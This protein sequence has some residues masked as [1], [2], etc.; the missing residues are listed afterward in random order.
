MNYGDNMLHRKV[1]EKNTIWNRFIQEVTNRNFETLSTIQKNAVL[2]FHYDTEMNSGG[3]S[4]FFENYPE[5]PVKDL[6]SALTA[7]SR[8]E[9]ADNFHD[10]LVSCHCDDYK[11]TDTV[12]YN[13]SP[14]LSDCLREYI[15]RN[16]DN[17]FS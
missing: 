3:H 4:C 17:I 2:C 6:I 11:E 10:A 9:I 8:K 7:V 13:F 5:T 12:F 15:E 14:S 16:K 1:T